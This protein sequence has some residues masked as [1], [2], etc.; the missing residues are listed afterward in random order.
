MNG[1]EK[2]YMPPHIGDV[3]SA[4]EFG[5][6]LSNPHDARHWEYI[7]QEVPTIPSGI[8][9]YEDRII[10]EAVHTVK[11]EYTPEEHA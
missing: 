7:T 9:V 1:P 8:V 3:N 4:E 6:D 11:R 5:L 10:R 2:A